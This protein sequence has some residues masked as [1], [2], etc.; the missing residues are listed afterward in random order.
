MKLARA[1]LEG[2]ELSPVT[3][4]QQADFEPL[5]GLGQTSMQ[6]PADFQRCA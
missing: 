5:S 6:L 3:Q 1:Y 2:R 4:A